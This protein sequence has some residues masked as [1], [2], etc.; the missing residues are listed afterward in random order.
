[1][2]ETIRTSYMDEV[3]IKKIQGSLDELEPYLKAK[4]AQ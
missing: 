3:Y 4:N 2:K 1:M